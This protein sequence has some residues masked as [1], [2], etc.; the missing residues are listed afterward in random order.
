MPDLRALSKMVKDVTSKDVER[1][2]SA[3][4]LKCKLPQDI[5]LTPEFNLGVSKLVMKQALVRFKECQGS[6][7]RNR[8]GKDTVGDAMKNGVYVFFCTCCNTFL[9]SMDG[10]CPENKHHKLKVVKVWCNADCAKY[11]V[12]V[13]R[14][15]KILADGT[16]FDGFCFD[17][18]LDISEYILG[19]KCF[20]VT[21]NKGVGFSIDFTKDGDRLADEYQPEVSP[22]WNLLDREGF[23]R[24]KEWKTKLCPYFKAGKCK[25]GSCVCFGAHGMHEVRKLLFVHTSRSE[26]RE[27]EKLEPNCHFTS[28]HQAESTAKKIAMSSPQVRIV[29][30]HHW[31]PKPK[32]LPKE[33]PSPKKV[34]TEASWWKP[35]RCQQAN[36]PASGPSASRA[37]P[38]PATAEPVPAGPVT[39]Q[40]PGLHPRPSETP[41]GS[42]VTDKICGSLLPQLAQ[43]T[44]DLV[45]IPAPV[46]LQ[47]LNP[48][49]EDL[50]RSLDPAPSQDQISAGPVPSPTASGSSHT[51][52]SAA[53]TT[54]QVSA[55][56]HDPQVAR[57]E[58]EAA[59]VGWPD[60]PATPSSSKTHST[61]SVNPQPETTTAIVDACNILWSKKEFGDFLEDFSQRARPYFNYKTWDKLKGRWKIPLGWAEGFLDLLMEYCIKKEYKRVVVFF[62]VSIQDTSDGESFTKKWEGKRGKTDIEVSWC[63]FD[64]KPKEASYILPVNDDHFQLKLANALIADDEDVVIISNDSFDKKE[65]FGQGKCPASGKPWLTYVSNYSFA[66][67]RVL[68]KPRS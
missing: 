41:T 2:K 6:L 62:P 36:S 54:S 56:P 11:I 65:D 29:G 3:G 12:G 1:P 48:E 21:Q 46:P 38:T 25:Y 27:A 49:T 30:P 58:M 8:L 18:F 7:R 4:E 53:Q 26:A 51:T 14:D 28:L 39:P 15:E 50:T 19:E 31:K 9:S 43:T 63:P 20:T 34:A 17:A 23:L 35:A 64:V 40:L 32:E 16:Y 24:S 61:D 37:L 67:G 10:V 59:G 47:A 22:F 55:G 13:Q 66:A 33:L 45:P 5:H 57:G 52:S 68:L 42:Q 60:R 44:S